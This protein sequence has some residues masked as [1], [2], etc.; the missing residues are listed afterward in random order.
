MLVN[1]FVLLSLFSFT[2]LLRVRHNSKGSSFN[3]AKTLENSKYPLTLRPKPS[4]FHQIYLKALKST[5]AE[6]RKHN[7]GYKKGHEGRCHRHRLLEGGQ[8]ELYI[9]L[10]AGIGESSRPCKGALFIRCTSITLKKNS[11]R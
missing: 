7:N 8:V 11:N 1:T 3:K 9:G 10:D 5:F 6:E 4:F 2:A